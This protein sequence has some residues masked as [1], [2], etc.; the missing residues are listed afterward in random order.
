M[1]KILKWEPFKELATYFI[2][3]GDK[4]GGEN[5]HRDSVGVVYY[6]SKWPEDNDNPLQGVNVIEMYTRMAVPLDQFDID[7]FLEEFESYNDMIQKCKQEI[8][9]ESSN[10]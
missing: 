4:Y 9:N 5:L 2:P 6:I 3:Y 10:S 1:Q 8:K 7:C